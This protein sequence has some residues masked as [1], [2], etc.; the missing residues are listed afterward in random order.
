VKMGLSRTSIPVVAVAA[1]LFTSH[2]QAGM[3]EADLVVQNDQSVPISHETEDFDGL[4]QFLKE[5][6]CDGPSLV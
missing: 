2:A 6:R 1:M 5:E 4:Y 3:F